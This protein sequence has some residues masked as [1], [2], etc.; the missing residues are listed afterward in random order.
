MLSALGDDD[1]AEAL[2]ILL[3]PVIADKRVDIGRAVVPMERLNFIL[4]NKTE[5]FGEVSYHQK[6]SFLQALLLLLHET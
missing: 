4:Y 6:F 2:E 3:L 1:V 5:V